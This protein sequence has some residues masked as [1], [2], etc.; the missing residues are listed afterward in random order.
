MF[1]F[2]SL[3]FVISC[4]LEKVTCLLDFMQYNFYMKYIFITLLEPE[5]ELSYNV[6]HTFGYKK[7]MP[8]LFMKASLPVL[9][10]L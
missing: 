6:L 10:D 4:L 2:I 1:G 9:S 5:F 7:E 3:L 8:R